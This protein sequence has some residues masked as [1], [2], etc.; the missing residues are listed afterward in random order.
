[1][2]IEAQ[3][4]KMLKQVISKT[5]N[6]LE[7]I[8]LVEIINFHST[9]SNKLVTHMLGNDHFK[10]FPNIAKLL[11]HKKN[12][13]V[14]HFSNIQ[15][16][17]PIIIIM[18]LLYLSKFHITACAFSKSFLATKIPFMDCDMRITFTSKVS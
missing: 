8:I 18:Y 15:A 10:P 1:M 14:Y 6:N 13:T 2:L 17:L 16:L 12:G 11:Y 5:V 4:T 9:E 3:I 7:N